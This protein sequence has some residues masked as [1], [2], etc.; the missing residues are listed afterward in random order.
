MQNDDIQNE[1]IQSGQKTFD[2]EKTARQNAP[3][4]TRGENKL[5][6]LSVKKLILK[7]GLPMI[8]SMVLQA[9]SY[10]L[11]PLVLSVMRLA[12]FVFPPAYL[13]A[14]GQ[15]VLNSVWWSF[16]IAEV[17][18]DVFAFIFLKQ[19]EAKKIQP[20]LNNGD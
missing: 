3:R 1:N 4:E 8:I 18:T 6:T 10:S 16:L 7:L 17:L 15:N 2:E 20:L 14:R 12:V 9:L 11:K 19:A 13:F 5:Q